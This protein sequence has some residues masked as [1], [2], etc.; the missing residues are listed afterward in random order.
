MQSSG[1]E[2]PSA[3]EEVAAT[4]T[5]QGIRA[6]AQR[7]KDKATET[8]EEQRERGR[9]R[10]M[11]VAVTGTIM[12]VVVAAVV[13]LVGVLVFSQVA[14]TMPTPDNGQLAN[15]TDSIVSTTGNVFDLAVVVLVV[16]VASAILGI[17][18]RLG[19]DGR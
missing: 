7:L 8:Y 3:A 11:S 15:T 17:V 10:V 4:T 13:L 19:G 9:G 5:T 14:S 18:M 1:P 12:T 16:L 6:G 2:G